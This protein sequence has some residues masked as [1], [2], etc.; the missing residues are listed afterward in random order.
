VLFTESG[1]RSAPLSKRGLDAE[2]HAIP[3]FDNN[4]EVQMD[5]IDIQRLKQVAGQK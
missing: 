3:W 2:N 1:A 5:K 4:A